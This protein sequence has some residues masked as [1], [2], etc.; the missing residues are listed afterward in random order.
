MSADR[1]PALRI[2]GATRL[3]A[4]VG[5]PIAQVRSPVVFSERFAALGANA[6]LIPAQVPPA[7]FE[8]VFGALMALRN[9]DGLL[10]TVPFK[11]R[12][13]PFAARLGKTAATIGALNA[14]RRETD[15]SWTGEMFD[16]A[17]FVRAVD[18]KG[19]RI[20]ERRV[21]LF[22]AGGAGS[23][24]ACALAEA[25]AASIHLIDPF[26]GRTAALADKLAAAFPG[27]R[28][29]TA[30]AVPEGTDMIVN[31]STVG[32]HAEDGL[33]GPIGTLDQGTL[34]GDVIV[35]EAPTALLR[36]AH[37]RGCAT[38]NGR[39]MLAG[40]ADAIAAFF[41]ATLSRA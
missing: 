19:E 26:P 34:V 27:C 35:S 1:T 10:V 14:L 16:G 23:A 41:A 22:G 29:V 38:V 25:R 2:D 7:Q 33:P 21:A 5:D 30:T 9:L 40:Q 24:I 31:A 39:E 15:G 11:P 12:A 18:A 8:A 13:V 20:R 28:F 17:G 3:Y 6:V 4:I 32:M 36:Q 37:E